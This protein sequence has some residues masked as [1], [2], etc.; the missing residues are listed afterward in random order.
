M[1]KGKNFLMALA[2]SA[3]IH[4]GIFGGAVC[5]HRIHMP[6][7]RPNRPKITNPVLHEER[8]GGPGKKPGKNA[9][10]EALENE[11]A[12]YVKELLGMLERGEKIRL[13]E[14][15]IRAEALD[16]NIRLAKEGKPGKSW[17]KFREMYVKLVG[18][19]VL[20]A[21]DAENGLKALL[22]FIHKKTSG[23][24]PKSGSI[25]EALERGWYNCKS[26]T[27]LF[28]AL[29]EDV[30]GR[31]DYEV[32]IFDEHFANLVGGKKVE[33]D[34][35]E[36]EG[37]VSR[38]DG[39]GLAVSRDMFIAAYLLGN[40]VTQEMIP[41]RLVNPYLVKKKWGKHCAATGKG[42]SGDLSGG[43]YLFPRPGV[44]SGLPEPP[45][46]F[47]PN[48]KHNADMEK[49]VEFARALFAAYKISHLH[50]EKEFVPTRLG[51]GEIRVNPIPLPEADWG[52]VLERF[53]GKFSFNS[54]QGVWPVRIMC[55]KTLAEIPPGT[56]PDIV[57]K[58][59]GEEAEKFGRY[60]R[61]SICM[62]MKGAAEGTGNM[63]EL[64]TYCAYTFCPA[65][66]PE[67]NEALKRRYLREKNP[68]LLR[69]A[70]GYSR[71]RGNFDFFL[72]EFRDPAGPEIK[73][74][75]A[76][77]MA[78]SD[79][80]RGCGM[81]KSLPEAERLELGDQLVWGCGDPNTAWRR[82][83]LGGLSGYREEPF[84]YDETAKILNGREMGPEKCAWIAA[85]APASGGGIKMEVARLLLECG[86][87]GRA[88]EMTKEAIEGVKEGGTE[89]TLD[90]VS[91]FPREFNADFAG[92]VG[93]N[94]HSPAPW[95]EGRIAL[96][97]ICNGGYMDYLPKVTE[98]LRG[99]AANG[100]ED[101]ENRVVAAYL[102]L[103]IG[104]EPF[105][106]K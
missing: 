105:E 48:K 30:L 57:E 66:Y 47:I 8:L 37:A 60:G 39:C 23:Y 10:L 84:E 68:E 82:V 101:F 5:V 98:T 59:S 49:V 94:P 93:T 73:K 55:G 19:A 22:G 75:A 103:K 42:K 25:L 43:T 20:E 65:E 89:G 58:M 69:F 28:S 33:L 72:N 88:R 36:G 6:P 35:E 15:L 91:P 52:E 7:E 4:S 1:G 50:D 54:L 97:M 78:L 18:E 64:L 34:P 14:F 17:G 29:M 12:E 44:K 67:V 24:F 74:A 46:V 61:E 100:E 41:E 16:E 40:G 95:L 45:P 32:L 31:R 53:R 63:V 62:R 27:E 106:K 86:D 26:S 13:S 104:V 56:I 102:L 79:H 2:A 9:R 87:K 90:L 3:A 81:L 76:A 38:F 21:G 11:R 70:L 85:R 77:G 71:V 51:K 83:E 99:L 92:F 96:A 80:E